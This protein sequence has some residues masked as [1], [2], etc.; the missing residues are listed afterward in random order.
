[1]KIFQL[2]SLSM[3]SFRREKVS[4]SEIATSQGM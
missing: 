1:M 3:S 4:G 2:L